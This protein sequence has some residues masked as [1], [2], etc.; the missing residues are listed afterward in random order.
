MSG[1]N[2]PQ[3]GLTRR[4]FL[5]MAAAAAGAAVL[6]GGASLIALADDAAPVGSGEEQVFSGVCRPNCMM[7]C[8]LNVHVRDGHVVK[9]TM[10]ECGDGSWNRACLRGRSLVQRTYSDRRVL[11]PLRRVGERGAGK[12]ERISWDDAISEIASKFAEVRESYGS[13]AIAFY[14]GTGNYGAVHGA[15]GGRMVSRLVN[16]LEATSLVLDTDMGISYGM[17]RT[18]GC[19]G[20]D[21][22]NSNG[23][24]D[25]PNARLIVLW[26]HNMSEAH[27][28]EWHWVANALELGAKLVVIDPMATLCAMRANMF[29]P[30]RPGSDSVLALGLI[31]VIIEEGRQNQEFLKSR[32]VG[33]CLVREDD[34]KFYRV[35]GDSSDVGGLACWDES[36]GALAPLNVAASPL[37]EGTFNIDGVKVV[38]AY[39]LLKDSVKEFTPEYVSGYTDLSPE[40]I[41]DLAHVLVDVSPVTFRVGFGADRYANG[42][43]AGHAIATLGAVLGNA[44]YPGASASGPYTCPSDFP[45]D[46]SYSVASDKMA[47]NLDVTVLGDVVESGKFKG[48]DYPVKALYITHANLVANRLNQNRWLNETL[49]K[50]DFIVYSAVEMNDTADIADIILPAAFWFEAEDHVSGGR[51]Q[52]VYHQDKIIDPLGESRSDGDIVRL[53][54]EKM[55]FGEFFDKSD[56][57]LVESIIAAHDQD[58]QDGYWRDGYAPKINFGSVQYAETGFLTPSGRVEFY[59][60]N[61]A[62]RTDTGVDPA[63]YH[64]PLPRFSTPEEAWPENPLAEKYPLVLLTEHNRYRVH[65]GWFEIPMLRELD[66]EPM[67]SISGADAQSRGIESG[68]LVEVFNDRGRCVVRAK[69]DERM[70][71]GQVNIPKGWQRSQYI[72]GCAQEL[73]GSIWD[74]LG[75]NCCWFDCL[76]EVRPWKEGE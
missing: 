4:S 59:W 1:T 45:E 70:R 76:V 24:E 46:F 62:T 74:K 27:V 10:K 19:L 16:L 11:Y 14:M 58:W 8:P 64:E 30:L 42:T 2:S 57:E 21:I 73:M 26:G 69:I 56:R 23:M 66:P 60:E 63:K 38:T 33:P 12:W 51:A 61:A 49:P 44:G 48:E 65:A 47:T 17:S 72:E 71:P 22:V 32:T 67:V 40:A 25:L 34:G 35:G 68:D 52:Y 50:I 37:L 29:V 39:T 9:T 36:T 55:G 31:N 13:R 54:A 3:G 53:L 15:S 7:I 28:Q 6:G 18:F 43:S 75:T 5:G 20:A 41:V